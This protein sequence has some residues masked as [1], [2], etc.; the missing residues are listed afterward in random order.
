MP[1]NR[2][3]FLGATGS[4]LLA[5]AIRPAEAVALSPPDERPNFLF[6]IADDMTFRTIRA[7]NNPEVHTPNLDRLV[8]QGT[9][10]THCFHQGSWMPAVCAPSRTMLNS[11]L[12]CFHARDAAQR[13]SSY[14]P[15]RIPPADPCT[16]IGSIP[17][18]SNPAQIFDMTA[19]PYETN[20]LYGT[21]QGTKLH[22]PLLATL[23]Q[24]QKQL[25]D[26][27]DIDYPTGA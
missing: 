5:N 13:F 26:N 17:A 22:A 16:A 2:R 1:L 18:C 14:Q 27:V 11:G 8:A 6:M 10:F 9:A 15:N 24:L 23:K 21:P 20:D 12:S 25:G 4:S 19:D 7:L 3:Q